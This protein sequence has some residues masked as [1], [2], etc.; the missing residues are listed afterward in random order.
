MGNENGKILK[1]MLE[2]TY[3][4]SAGQDETKRVYIKNLQTFLCAGLA[5][6]K[7]SC[8]P[9]YHNGSL[10]LAFELENHTHPCPS[11][12]LTRALE[13]YEQRKQLY[14]SDGGPEQLTLTQMDFEKENDI[15]EKEHPEK[16]PVKKLEEEEESVQ[17]RPKPDEPE[18]KKTKQQ[19]ELKDSMIEDVPMPTYKRITADH[20]VSG[21]NLTLTWQ[22]EIDEIS[23]H[24]GEEKYQISVPGKHKA[25]IM[26]N[27]C[28]RNEIIQVVFNGSVSDFAYEWEKNQLEE[29]SHSMDESHPKDG[30]KKNTE[31]E[32]NEYRIVVKD[33]QGGAKDESSR[34]NVMPLTP[35][36]EGPCPIYVVVED[37]YGE[38]TAYC[39]SETPTIDDI[40]AGSHTFL[41]T[42]AYE[43]G[44]FVVDIFGRRET[45][46]RSKYYIDI[47]EKKW[48]KDAPPAFVGH[49]VQ[50]IRGKQKDAVIHVLPLGKENDENG[51]VPI[52]VCVETNIYKENEKQTVKERYYD[53]Y[54]C[55]FNDQVAFTFDNERKT[56]TALWDGR[57][58]KSFVE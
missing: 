42:G 35:T 38:K 46:D 28:P 19:P 5:T 18:R 1:K 36:A 34:I 49:P 22:G 17:E 20:D 25:R 30:W 4:L 8:I 43:E 23:I 48:R 13:S 3:S 51:Q 16:I 10:I 11:L 24:A 58:L 27:D 41:V 37:V 29:D 52:G 57:V 55:S 45:A 50:T 39:S 7:V 56:V 54:V 6:E 33:I 9:S 32:F 40:R 14:Q 21:E 47:S 15:P 31:L 53:S 26:I 12:I 44:E 2:S